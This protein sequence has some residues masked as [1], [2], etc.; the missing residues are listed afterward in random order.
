MDAGDRPHRPR[1]SLRLVPY[2]RRVMSLPKDGRRCLLAQFD[3]S[4]VVVFQ[5]YNDQIARFSV[6]H[7]YF[8]GDFSFQRMSWVKPSFTW[9][10]HRSGW[11]TKHN[12]EN[13]L[14]LRLRRDYWEDVLSKAV[15]SS[16]PTSEAPLT[17]HTDSNGA[18]ARTSWH[19]ELCRSTVVMQW[20]PEHEPFSGK[21]VGHRVIQLGLRGDTLAAFRGPAFTGS[22]C[23]EDITDFVHETAESR[24][25]RGGYSSEVGSSHWG[26]DD[27]APLMVP[28]ETFYPILNEHTAERLGIKSQP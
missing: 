22:S 2:S 27:Q 20:D 25:L 21:R 10:C 4:S 19:R 9:M 12:Q 26:N 5:A 14:A 1:C 18:D 17:G 3:D 16:P 13:I 7:G 24:C 11:A 23:I 6:D 15:L 28:E 8:G